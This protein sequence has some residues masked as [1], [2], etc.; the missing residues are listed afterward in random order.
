MRAWLRIF[1]HKPQACFCDFKCLHACTASSDLLGLQ[2]Q[3]SK[4]SQLAMLLHAQLRAAAAQQ[5]IEMSLPLTEGGRK[6]T[7]PSKPSLDVS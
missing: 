7:S 6:P 3:L 5:Q 4:S 1:K 2:P